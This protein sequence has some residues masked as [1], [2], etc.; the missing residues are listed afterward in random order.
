MSRTVRILTA[1]YGYLLRLYPLDYRA[2]FADEMR[3][4]FADALRD[5]ARTGSWAA[6]RLFL[7][8]LT[9]LPASLWHASRLYPSPS[10]YA[11]RLSRARWSA[12]YFSIFWGGYMLY[13]A[14]QRT[15]D[16]GD[17]TVL[18]AV[19]M[20]PSLALVLAWR[21]ER[22][23]GMLTML[24][25]AVLC[26][27]GV[28]GGYNAAQGEPLLTQLATLSAGLMWGAAYLVFGG[29]YVWVANKAR[30]VETPRA[31]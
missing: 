9:S 16:S 14:V 17:L 15:L 30:S 23:G 12:R 19:Q 21:W 27:L 6:A 24:G 25:G 4:V 29:L 20:V 7:R 1:L 18:R 13:F 22:Q 2:A 8:E 26:G 3:V 11:D 31:N 10:I 5:A 28:I